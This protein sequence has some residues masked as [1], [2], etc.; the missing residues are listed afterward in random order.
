MIGDL[1]FIFTTTA[2]LLTLAGHHLQV[3]ETAGVPSRACAKPSLNKW[4]TDVRQAPRQK[5]LYQCP[6]CRYSTLHS[7]GMKRHLRT[8]TGERP[9]ACT[10]CQ[11]KFTQKG[12]LQAHM[13]THTGLKPFACTICSFSTVHKSHL[14]RHMLNHSVEF[15]PS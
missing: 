12:S 4:I 3:R 15:E 14:V 7:T 9:F 6:Y 2:S 11:Q 13:T 10:V 5:Q 8:H 1:Y